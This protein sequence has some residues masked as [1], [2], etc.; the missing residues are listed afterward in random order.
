MDTTSGWRDWG[1][2]FVVTVK[3]SHL[4]L[5]K[6]LHS[7][8]GSAECHIRASNCLSRE[9]AWKSDGVT[10]IEILPASDLVPIEVFVFD[11]RPSD[12][13]LIVIG[14]TWFFAMPDK[15]FSKRFK[16]QDHRESW[17]T[18]GRIRLDVSSSELVEIS[19]PNDASYKYSKFGVGSLAT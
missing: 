6:N 3:I 8:E 15:S 16:L 12:S 19:V 14:S 4:S 5:Q 1:D 9:I 13:E 10:S 11:R 17:R 2:A 18:V 7:G